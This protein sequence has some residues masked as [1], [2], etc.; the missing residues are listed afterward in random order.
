MAFDRERA[1]A[2]IEALITQLYQFNRENSGID[3]V[4]PVQVKEETVDD[5][6]VNGWDLD[7]MVKKF[8]PF[9]DSVSTL[10]CGRRFSDTLNLGKHPVN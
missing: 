4:L 5:A 6:E 1:Y 3:V 7:T 8:A 9:L 2:T 10:S